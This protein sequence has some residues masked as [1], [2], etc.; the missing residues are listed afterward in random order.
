MFS[1]CLREGSSAGRWRR[2]G[3]TLQGP[4]GWIEVLDH[5]MVEAHAVVH[6]GKLGLAILERPHPGEPA[7]PDAGLAHVDGATWA[8]AREQARD[9][10]LHWFWLEADGRGLT[11]ESSPL[12]TV[13]VFLTSVGGAARAHWDPLQLLPFLR[14]RLNQEAAAYYLCSFDQPY[15]NETLLEDLH[16]LAGGYQARWK[17]SGGGWQWVRPPSHEVPH[18]RA[19][20][21]QADPVRTFEGLLAAATE[22]RVGALHRV[23]SGLSGGLDS[24][25]VSGALARQGHEVHTFGILV[26]DGEEA[27]QPRR[28]DS[29]V[30]HFGLVDQV[31]RIAPDYSPW[32]RAE[33]EPM[34]PWDELY[35]APFEDLY[36]RAA[37]AGHQVFFTGLGGDD[38]L[39]P[40]WDELPDRGLAE[41]TAL[42]GEPEPPDFLTARVREGRVERAQARNALPRAFVQRSVLDS[43]AGL[44]AQAL[45][46]GLWPIHPLVTPEVVRY[47]HALPTEHRQ[48]RTLMR[49]TLR[50][51]G[52]PALVSHP[53]STESF[54]ATCARAMRRCPS[55]SRLLRAPRLADLGLV[56]PARVE[57]AFQRWVSQGRPSSEGVHFVAIATLEATLEALESSR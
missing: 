20:S 41:R 10:P 23:A 28:R 4:G 1:L 33:R 53:E 39:Q 43:T 35:T 12:P 55:F 47:C 56:E 36:A 9:W 37:A 27:G 11:L 51:W 13:P 30:H 44:A 50:R 49:E 40:Y 2:S 15:S 14:P 8:M 48:R 26:P 31:H 21:L 16:H 57:R 18:P 19:L 54:E 24:T 45:R 32:A 3:R 42:E 38:L 17:A 29:A 22:Q 5:P 52:L 46:H 6:D 25:L 34:L 7:P